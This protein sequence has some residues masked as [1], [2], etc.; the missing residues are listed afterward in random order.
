VL[1]VLDILK[2]NADQLFQLKQ[3]VVADKQVCAHNTTCQVTKQA[4]IPKTF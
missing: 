1:A 3:K 2:K 4:S